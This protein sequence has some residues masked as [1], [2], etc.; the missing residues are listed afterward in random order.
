MTSHIQTESRGGSSLEL[1]RLFW[2][3][4]SPSVDE[5]SGYPFMKNACTFQ[6]SHILVHFSPRSQRSKTALGRGHPTI[7]VGFSRSDHRLPLLVKA[8]CLPVAETW[9]YCSLFGVTLRVNRS[10]LRPGACAVVLASTDA[11]RCRWG[12]PG[13]YWKDKREYLLNDGISGNVSTAQLFRM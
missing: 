10:H 9:I 7:Q 13:Y 11:Y 4:I 12:E 2:V 3:F 1:S 6:I 8:C 5:R